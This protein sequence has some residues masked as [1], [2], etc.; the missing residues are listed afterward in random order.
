[1]FSEYSR[2]VSHANWREKARTG[3]QVLEHYCGHGTF[4]DRLGKFR[5]A[6]RPSLST[7]NFRENEALLL[8][9]L[10]AFDLASLLREDFETARGGFLG[11]AALSELGA[12]G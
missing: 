6:V 7:P 2:L 9:S 8:L 10:A 1:M 12:Q 5:A 11:L 3:L 4:E